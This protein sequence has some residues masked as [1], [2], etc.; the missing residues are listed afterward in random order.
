LE[1]GVLNEGISGNRLL[2]DGAG[3]I[4]EDLFERDVLDQPGVRWVGFSDDPINDLGSTRPAPSAAALIAAIERLI[5]KAHAQHIR[6]FC[7]TLTSY[8]GG[9]N[10]RREG[11]AAGSST[12]S[13]AKAGVAAMAL[14]TGT[15]RRM[16]PPNH[17]VF[18]P[19]YDSGDHLH[20][21]DA[22]HKAIGNTLDLSLVF[23]N[24]E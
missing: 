3:P 6:F 18:F 12:H 1:I 9:I 7:S 22:G 10:T 23:P 14:A 4:A 2:V 24:A 21:S 19:T 13:C 16:I 8:E 11:E 17:H 20:P 15:R 5:E